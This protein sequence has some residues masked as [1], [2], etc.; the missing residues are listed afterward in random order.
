MKKKFLLKRIDLLTVSLNSLIIRNNKREDSKTAKRIQ[1]YIRNKKYKQRYNFI[2]LIKY[3]N[4]TQNLVSESKIHILA[5]LILEHNKF[6]SEKKK[7]KDYVIKFCYKYRSNKMY[8]IN[9]KI[10]SSKNGEKTHIIEKAI[11]SIYI[12]TKLT[13][14]R[15]IY[16]LIKYLH[17]SNI[18]T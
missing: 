10:M 9:H 6:I 3:L 11:I 15:G 8:Y 17:N 14:Y 5:G 1:N 13:D 18:E 4:L 16:F 7:L 2:N 12:M